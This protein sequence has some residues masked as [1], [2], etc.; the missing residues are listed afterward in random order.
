MVQFR[1]YVDDD[2]KPRAQVAPPHEVLEWFLEVEV[3][4][5]LVLVARLI[6][7]ID[8][9]MKAPV[10]VGTLVEGSSEES[11]WWFGDAAKIRYREMD[12]PLEVE[13]S[14]TALRFILEKWRAV[15]NDII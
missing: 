13:M 7:D 6:A 10:G 1:V 12:P 15:V 14:L 9:A 4:V 8:E 3:G 11:Q 2:G 5:D